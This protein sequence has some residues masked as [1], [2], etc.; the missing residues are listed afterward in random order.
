MKKVLI[1]AS[2]AMATLAALPAYAC[3]G[4]NCPPPHKVP[5]ISA[6]EGGAAIAALAAIVLIAWERRRRAA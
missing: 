3:G 1:G 2:A 5:E 6:L 4:L